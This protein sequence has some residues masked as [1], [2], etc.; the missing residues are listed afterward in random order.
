MQ[1]Y[2][3][4]EELDF[5][6]CAVKHACKSLRLNFGHLSEVYRRDKK[7]WKINAD[8]VVEESLIAYLSNCT[9]YSILSEE[10]GEVVGQGAFRWIIDP[11]DGSAN[12]NRGMPL[13]CISVALWGG[14]Q[15]LVGV[16]LDV[17]R[18][19]LFTG[20]V[21]SGAWCNGDPIN[22]SAN[23]DPS[24]G[25]L[26]T[27]FPTVFSF[28]DEAMKVAGKTYNRFGKIRM[29]GSAALML[30]WIACGRADSYWEKGIALWDVAA[31]LALVRSAGGV[32]EFG[33][34]GVDNRLN[35]AAGST[36]NMIVRE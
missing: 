35:V 15:P 18:E 10:R 31:G 3:F 20:I 33:A 27:G 25:V 23:D 30:S 17:F 36:R 32:L 11:V 1:R 24:V 16:V 4:N 34:I 12:L 22:V 7:E 8:R 14:N 2:R 26:C 6:I 5:A 9:K 28:T 19:E 21:G 29:L 13:S